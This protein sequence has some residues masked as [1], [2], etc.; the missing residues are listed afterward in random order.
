[1]RAFAVTSSIL[2]AIQPAILAVAKIGVYSSFGMPSV[3]KTRPEIRSTF[4][5]IA[6]LLFFSTAMIFG[7]SASESVAGM[8]ELLGDRALAGQWK[9][10]VGHA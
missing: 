2:C 6:L 5:Q 9:E 8:I 1:M 4:A 7:A 10:L 3:R